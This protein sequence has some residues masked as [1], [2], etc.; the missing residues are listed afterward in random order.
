MGSWD[1]HTLQLPSLNI[2][3]LETKAKAHED[4][5]ERSDINLN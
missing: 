5:W 1:Q 2:A 3:T 4:F